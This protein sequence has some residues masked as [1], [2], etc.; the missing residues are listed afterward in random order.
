[1]HEPGVD[2]LA[3][4]RS[5]PRPRPASCSAR[6][7]ARF[8]AGR[9]VP[10]SGLS[11]KL[12]IRMPAGSADSSSRNRPSTNTSR[13]PSSK[14]KK[15]EQVGAVGQRRER[16]VKRRLGNGAQAGVF[17]SLLADA[18]AG[19]EARNSDAAPSP[20]PTISGQAL[21]QTRRSGRE[22]RQR[23]FARPRSCRLRARCRRSRS[24]P[25]PARVP[26]RRT[27]RSG[28]PAARARD[29]ARCGR[30]GAGDG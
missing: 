5:R 15:R 1:M 2:A 16:F 3:A 25:A 9:S 12:S 19:P 29:P 20:D 11:A 21:A 10:K 14:R 18:S 22:S 27:A 13:G 7:A 26:A 6:R 28:R 23:R 30:A 17:P 24:P 4:R 8:R